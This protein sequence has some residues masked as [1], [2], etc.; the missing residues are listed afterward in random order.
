MRAWTGGT[1][2]NPR[3]GGGMSFYACVDRRR[4]V[5]FIAVGLAVVL[6]VRGEAASLKGGTQFIPGLLYAYVEGRIRDCFD[7]LV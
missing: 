5:G 6:C 2:E 1:P 3:F 4:C 7:F